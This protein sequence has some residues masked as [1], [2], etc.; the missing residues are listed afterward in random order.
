[1]SV[2]QDLIVRRHGQV[3]AQGK[4][5]SAVFS[6]IHRRPLKLAAIDFPEGLPEAVDGGI[7]DFLVLG[8]SAEDMAE[9]YRHTVRVSD[10]D[11]SHHM[12]NLRYIGMFQDAFDSGFGPDFNAGEVR[13]NLLS[14]GREGEALSVR[15]RLDGNTLRMA[16]AHGDGGLAA[17]AAFIR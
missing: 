13:I 16:A 7:P 5:E 6:L 3:A 4:L 14:Q 2:K 15:S 11:K 9:R 10:L 1:M 17:V 8:K 12:T